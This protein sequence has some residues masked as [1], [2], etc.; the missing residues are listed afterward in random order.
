MKILLLFLVFLSVVSCDKEET[1]DY[2]KLLTATEWEQMTG[3]IDGSY[4][5]P[6]AK[7]FYRIRFKQNN[8][9][10]IDLDY[11]G[12][13]GVPDPVTLTTI[14]S[15][16]EIVLADRTISFPEP[17]DTLY[18][19]IETETTKLVIYFAK[20]KILKL[21]EDRLITEGVNSNQPGLVVG[22]DKLYFKAI[23]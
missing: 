10:E 9:V 22:G 4:T 23:E 12:V 15:K 5:S 7:Q 14:N 13:S 21:K 19:T 6:S 16:Y 11:L 18:Y 17:L 2:K 3:Y 20:L 8:L 1:L